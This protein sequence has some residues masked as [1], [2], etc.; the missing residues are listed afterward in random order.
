[1]EASITSAGWRRSLPESDTDAGLRVTHHR[2]KHVSKSYRKQNRPCESLTVLLL[3]SDENSGEGCQWHPCRFDEILL[4]S[5][6]YFRS[7]FWN[8]TA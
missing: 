7:R 2:R 3:L 4:R 1:M 5:T 6:G 8:I